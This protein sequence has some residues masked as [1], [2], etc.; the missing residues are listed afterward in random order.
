MRNG[1]DADRERAG[2]GAA[3]GGRPVVGVGSAGAQ[4]ERAGGEEGGQGQG[5]AHGWCPSVCRVGWCG[6]SA[7]QKAATTAPS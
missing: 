7:G 2:P 1:R 6:W 3:G 5:G 4:H